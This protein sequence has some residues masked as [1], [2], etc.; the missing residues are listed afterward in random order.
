MPVIFRVCLVLQIKLMDAGK[1]EILDMEVMVCDQYGSRISWVED[2]PLAHGIHGDR[3]PALLSE[4]QIYL[5]KSSKV[6]ASSSQLD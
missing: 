3:G 4:S 5:W 1:R 6:L 2:G